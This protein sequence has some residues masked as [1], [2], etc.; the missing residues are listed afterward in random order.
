MEKYIAFFPTNKTK[1]HI[2]LKPH[3]TEIQRSCSR[4]SLKI[5]PCADAGSLTPKTS[6][7][8]T[9]KLSL[10]KYT[11]Q[12]LNLLFKEWLPP[13]EPQTHVTSHEVVGKIFGK[14]LFLTELLALEV[15]VCSSACGWSTKRREGPNQYFSLCQLNKK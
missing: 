15:G 5:T 10:L 6:I 9:A 7:P 11:V 14:L 4:V 3:T 13:A 12:F 8:V 1:L 2:H